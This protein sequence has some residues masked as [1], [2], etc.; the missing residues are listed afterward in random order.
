M[1]KMV[2]IWLAVICCFILT[3]LTGCNDSEAKPHKGDFSF[4][5][6]DGYSITDMTEENC[7]IVST[8]NNVTV[9][10]VEVTSLKSGEL[11]DDATTNIMVYLQNEFH[12][13]NNV[14]FI[15]SRWGDNNPVVAINLTKTEDNAEEKSNF[16]HVFFE[17]AELVYHIWFDMNAI[18]Q[19]EADQVISV[20]IM[21]EN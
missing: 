9:G 7:K 19:D 21:N 11:D 1:K 15:A 13:T 12:K 20:A 2:G 5:M 16:Y 17:K 4:D 6:M 3:A 8:Q 18:S 14:E 10:G